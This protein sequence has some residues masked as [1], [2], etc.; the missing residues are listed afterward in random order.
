MNRYF[1]CEACSSYQPP[2]PPN[3]TVRQLTG[4]LLQV[5]TC[6]LCRVALEIGDTCTCITVS[7][8]GDV[9]LYWEPDFISG[10]PDPKQ[11]PYPRDRGPYEVEP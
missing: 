2:L 7:V 3:A 11:G 1:R 9:Y 8:P 5:A 4:P 6:D 10:I